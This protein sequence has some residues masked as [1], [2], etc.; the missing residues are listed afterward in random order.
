MD[1]TGSLVQPQP[2]IHCQDELCDQVTGTCVDQSDSEY[3]VYSWNCKDLYKTIGLALGYGPIQFVH[4]M[5]GRLIS[6]PRSRAPC[7]FSPTR[8]T[9]GSVNV[10]QGIAA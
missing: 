1:C 9:S 2:M 4:G 5:G 10:D 6:I 3:S 7:S 8:E